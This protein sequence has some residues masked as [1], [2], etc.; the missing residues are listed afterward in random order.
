MAHPQMISEEAEEGEAGLN[1]ARA[2][3]RWNG[4]WRAPCV[5]GVT[6]NHTC[7]HSALSARL[8]FLHKKD[9]TS[10]SD[11]NSPEP[12]IMMEPLFITQWSQRCV[13]AL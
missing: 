10:E 8:V 3:A 5:M 2:S 1:I 6:G 7:Q 12:S 13:R 4:V 9:P 11:E